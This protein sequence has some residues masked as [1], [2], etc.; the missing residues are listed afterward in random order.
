MRKLLLFLLIIIAGCKV[1]VDWYDI[2]KRNFDSENWTSARKNFNYA[3]EENHKNKDSALF[4]LSIIDSLELIEKAKQEK[5]IKQKI[6]ESIISKI[7]YIKELKTTDK[8]KTL[9]SIFFEIGIY[10][11]AWS[12][13][14]NLNPEENQEIIKNSKILEVTLKS[15]QD[16]RLPILRKEYGKLLD[17]KLWENNIDVYTSGSKFRILNITGAAFANNKNIKD[18]QTALHDA[19]VKL[20]FEQVRYKWYEQDD[21]FQYYNIESISDNTPF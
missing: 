11:N 7:G 14:S 9:E 8:P 4:Y 10:S 13:I 6:N 2:G 17:K 21:E 5:L 15:T 20:R 19:V 12:L 18:M 3:I 16:K 1:D